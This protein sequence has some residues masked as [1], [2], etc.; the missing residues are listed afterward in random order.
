MS[1]I[2]LDTLIFGVEDVAACGRYLTDYGLEPVGVT[3]AGGR[4]EA[5][6]GTAVVIA[7]SDDAS[8]PP[9]LKT[10]CQLRKT[11]MDVT[12]AVALDAIAKELGKDR[13]VRRLADG[14]IESIDD[15]GFV[16]GFVISKRRV[17]NQPGEVVNSPGASLQRPV[18]QLG[19]DANVGKIRP[20]GLSHIVYFVPDV[21]KAEAFY[22]QRLG[23]RCTDRFVELGPF[24][25]PPASLEHHTHFLIGM[26]AH[27]Q[28]VE[29]FTFHF[30]G[31][32]EL[33]QNGYRFIEKGYQGFWGPGRH[34]LGSNWFWY[35]NCPLG[36][37]MEMDA[38]MDLHDAA[39]QPRAVHVSADSSQAFLLRYR[40]KWSPGPGMHEHGDYV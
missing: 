3:A 31:P 16:I 17:I 28:G 19:V 23:F 24:L 39:W 18:N 34:L 40:K 6:D 20:R 30:A 27:M 13:E 35:F 26:P 7:R 25:Q 36:C 32:T 4:Y 5:L 29:H 21:K 15:S 11:I 10:G 1:I 14:S 33:L 37:H 2:G 8:L 22:A 9:A 12:N 38:D